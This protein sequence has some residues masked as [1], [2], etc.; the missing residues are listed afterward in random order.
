MT[1][2]LVNSLEDF[3]NDKSGLNFDV[4]E[5]GQKLSG[6]QKQRLAIAG[7][8]LSAACNLAF[9]EATSSVDQLTENALIR[10]V[11][12]ENKVSTIL[13]ITHKVALAEDFDKVVMLLN[14]SVSGVGTYETVASESDQ[15]VKLAPTSNVLTPTR[16]KLG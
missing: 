7:S 14:G 10:D 16:K 4:G 1:S 3:V 6:G 2:A 11:V 9:D 13:S 15:F 5:L 12:K 8:A